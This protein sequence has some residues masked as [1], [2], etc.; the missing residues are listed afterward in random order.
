MTYKSYPRRKDK[1][2][3]M[4]RKQERNRVFIHNRSIRA[5]LDREKRAERAVNNN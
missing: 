3:R 1:G 5:K 4:S 2:S